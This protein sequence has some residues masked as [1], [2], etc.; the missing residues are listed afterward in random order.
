MKSALVT[1][2][3]FFVS[4]GIF[5]QPVNTGNRI[6]FS[7]EM[8]PEILAAELLSKMTDEQALAQVFMLGWVGAE[9]SPLI[10]N[11][12]R[13]RNIG[14]VKIFGWN[15]EDTRKLAE[16]VGSLQKAALAGSFGIP[17]FVATD[18][19]GG[20][21]RHVKGATSE[22]P[23]NMAIGASG[24]PRDAYLA[25]YYIGRELAV[26][27]IN[28]NFAPTVDL[29][30]NSASTLIGP[31]AFGSD[32]VQAGILG[33]AFVRG[34]ESAG[35]I[36]TAKHYPGHGDTDLDSH[37]VLPQIN[38]PF[39]ILWDRELVP[40][41]ILVKEGIPAIMSGHLAF[42]NTPAA[43]VPASLS[44]WFLTDILRKRIGFQGLIITDD[45]MMNGATMSVGS[46]SRA[47]KQALMAGNDIIMLSSTPNL[48]DP[49]WTTLTGAMKQ[50]SDFRERVFDA[51]FRVLLAKLRYLKGEKAAPYVPDPGKVDTELPDPEGTAFFLDLAARSVT[52]VKGK[53]P[54]S[55]AKAGKVLLAG[56]FDDFFAAG[57]NAYPDAE[58]YRYSTARGSANFTYYANQADTVI[59][60]IS[61]AADL[62]MLRSLQ[63]LGKKVIVF[64]VLN[65]A[66]INDAPWADT[67]IAVYSYAKESFTA[68]F[69]ALLGKIPARGKLP[70]K[71]PAQDS[72]R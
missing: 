72:R 6:A 24:F 58:T 32:P 23:G 14:G 11:W 7:A 70:A 55:P 48:S 49:V 52:V 26:L 39:E 54:V 45:L 20:W 13:D 28:M 41:R 42:P 12:I 1:V 44:P 59:F 40:Y 5:S 29:Y 15:T 30:T 66:Y 25:G 3:L 60:C 57:K 51:A 38:A 63:N 67:A 22:T 9:P 4:L 8:Q 56:Q 46:L 18:Q 69:S 50:E 71:P 10:I 65:P 19:E 53:L 2:L 61:D 27:G 34:Q 64:S 36:A 37:G 33:A 62:S 17:L 21:I 16:T 43:S 68:G 47:A 31:R 35:V